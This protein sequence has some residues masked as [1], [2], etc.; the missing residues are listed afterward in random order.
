MQGLRAGLSAIILIQCMHMVM[1]DYRTRYCV[2]GVVVFG[3][4]RSEYYVI[5]VVRLGGYQSII[6]CCMAI[7][8]LLA[9]IVNHNICTC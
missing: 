5:G 3:G 1:A 6:C 4:Y 8:M 2:G 7:V 9:M